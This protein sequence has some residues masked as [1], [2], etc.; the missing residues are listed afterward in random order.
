MELPPSPRRRV[1]LMRHGAVTYFDA[2]GR[3][4]L[5][6]LVPLNETG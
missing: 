5:P 1:Y 4:A 6:E 3:P 2:T